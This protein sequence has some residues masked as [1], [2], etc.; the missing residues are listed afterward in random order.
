[1]SRSG[2]RTHI[3]V[4]VVHLRTQGTGVLVPP[5]TPAGSR[6]LDA[7]AR[8]PNALLRELRCRAERGL[9]LLTQRWAILQ[10][11]TT[12]PS[13]ITGITRA[14]LVLTQFAQVHQAKL[15]R[16]TLIEDR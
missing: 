7:G 2:R 11:V 15:G 9:A 5:K 14:T 12:S 4:G 6:D 8:T 3:P 1:M 13:R 10:H 16:I